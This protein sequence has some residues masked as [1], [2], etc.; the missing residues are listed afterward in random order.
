MSYIYICMKFE[1][2]VFFFFGVVLCL[3]FCFVNSVLHIYI[4]TLRIRLRLLIL[5]ICLSILGLCCL[6][7]GCADL[8]QW[9]SIRKE[10]YV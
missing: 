3:M 1:S 2:I 7:P 9:H 4:Y 6:I 5:V 10:D 8:T